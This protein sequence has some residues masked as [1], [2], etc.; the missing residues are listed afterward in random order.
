[1]TAEN[2]ALFEAALPLYNRML[3]MPTWEQITRT[4]ILG[5][6]ECAFNPANS[7]GDPYSLKQLIRDE[8]NP[9]F[10][11]NQDDFGA[12]QQTILYAFTKYSQ[13]INS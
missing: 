13:F 12:V 6:I 11:Y 4:G 7:G 8:W 3:S 10:D 1:M 2:I 5:D 9:L